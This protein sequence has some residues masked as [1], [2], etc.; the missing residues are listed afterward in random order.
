MTGR[1]ALNGGIILAA[2]AVVLVAVF[3]GGPSQTPVAQSGTSRHNVLLITLDTT[4]ADRLS[5]YGY[6]KE[7][8]PN[9]DA[10][11]SDGVRFDLAIAT[12]AVTPVS[13]ASILT[14]LNPYQH[15][16]RVFYG[17]VGHFLSAA[18]PTV[19]TILKSHGWH[20]A[21]FISAYPASERFGLHWGFDTFETGL[22]GRFVEY[23]DIINRA[24]G[25]GRA[26]GGVRRPT[27]P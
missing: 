18:H 2:I 27:G 17:P 10:L 15:D 6:H 25:T 24:Q 7:T 12:A 22:Q 21:A 5:C 19:A 4:R 9:L 14:G 23:A 1:T 20:T 26:L 16:V 3:R 8:T 13:H 11:A